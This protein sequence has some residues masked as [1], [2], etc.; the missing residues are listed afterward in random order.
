MAD[1]VRTLKIKRAGTPGTMPPPD[2]V[3]DALSVE[4]GQDASAAQGHVTLP[5]YA[6]VRTTGPVVKDSRK[7]T[8]AAIV[9]TLAVVAMLAL[10]VF[11]L[12]E[13][14]FYA[15]NPSVWTHP[16]MF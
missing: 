7:W 13:L 14:N 10:L 4:E 8:W 5:R 11:Q 2:S 9:A 6:Q 1:V 16:G 3:P 12:L 15:Q